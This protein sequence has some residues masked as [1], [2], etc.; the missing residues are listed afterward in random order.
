MSANGVNSLI[1][2]LMLLMKIDG[3][4]ATNIFILEARFWSSL[5]AIRPIQAP[6]V[7]NK[8]NHML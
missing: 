8:A 3:A 2:L 6:C 4:N 1:G 7:Q 5:N